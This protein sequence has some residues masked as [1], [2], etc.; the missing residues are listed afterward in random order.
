MSAADSANSTLPYWEPPEV[1]SHIPQCSCT[2]L[3]TH[4]APRAFPP[5]ACEITSCECRGYD[6]PS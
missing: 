4:H 2:H 3:I 6:G 1:L 5:R